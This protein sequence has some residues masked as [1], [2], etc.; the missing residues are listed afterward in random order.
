MNSKGVIKRK[1][2][3]KCAYVGDWVTSGMVPKVKSAY[4]VEAVTSMSVSC[5]MLGKRS[6]VRIMPKDVSLF[7]AFV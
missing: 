2:N 7:V 5:V 1:N 3:L 4:W 6:R